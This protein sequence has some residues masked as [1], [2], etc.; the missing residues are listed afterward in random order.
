[1]TTRRG[2]MSDKEKAYFLC[3]L[4]PPLWPVIPALLICDFGSW[5]GGRYRAW[6][7]RR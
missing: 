7:S 6:R 2:P 5:I 4:F 1:M 3:L